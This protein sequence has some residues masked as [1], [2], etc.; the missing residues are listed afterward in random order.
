MRKNDHVVGTCIGYTNEGLG[1]VKIDGFPLFVKGM[2]ETETGEL[3]V[4]LLKRSYGYAH[5]L[6]LHKTSPQRC[7]PSCPVA[8][9]CGGC[10]LQHM[11]YEEQL[12]FKKQKVQDVMERIARLSLSV[13]DVLGMDA[14]QHYRNKGQIPVGIEKGEVVTGFYRI[15]SHSII[16]TE[17]CM[18]QSKRINEV[19]KVMRELLRTYGN[20]AVFRHL[21]I[22]DGFQSGEVM[23]VWIVRQKRFA[24]RDEMVAELVRRL[25][26]IRSVVL[27]LN[28]RK[29]NVILGEEEELLYGKASIEDTLQGVRF[30]ISSKSFYQVNPLQT[31]VLYRKALEFCELQGEELVI[32]LYCGVGTISMFLA[33][34]AKQVIGVEIVAQAVANAQE[35]AKRSGIGN[36]SFVCSDAAAYAAKL[37]E[38][39][40]R[41]D[42]IVVDPPRKGC[43]RLTLDSMVKMA[44]KRIVYVSCDPATLARDLA[45]LANQG[46]ETRIVQPCDM[47]P[48]TAAVEC[49]ALIVRKEK[50]SNNK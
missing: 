19:L 37:S 45:I 44:P 4:T 46:Y 41:P 32:D 28:E 16:D 24:H 36:V 14:I 22:K 12:R 48:Y 18:I 27:N 47:F 38:A 49:V 42:V 17:H 34:K 21:L 1:V 10:Q 6:K 8:K 26:Y 33:Q 40:L 11:S 50:Q 39:Q 3:I 35:N 43:D 7:E 5:L 20:A 29:D 30:T 15:H 9:P 13:E 25:P 31:E 23:V 2:L